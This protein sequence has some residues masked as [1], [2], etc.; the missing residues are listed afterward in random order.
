MQSS[1]LFNLLRLLFNSFL[2]LS[3]SVGDLSLRLLNFIDWCGAVKERMRGHDVAGKTEH[4]KLG[5][6]LPQSFTQRSETY[7]SQ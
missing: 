3:C 6:Y 2:Q 1:E 4:Y 7:R 5:Q